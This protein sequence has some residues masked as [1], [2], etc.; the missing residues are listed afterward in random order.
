MTL[1]KNRLRRPVE[2]LAGVVGHPN[3][4][5]AFSGLLKSIFRA[6]GIELAAPDLARAAEAAS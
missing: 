4:S 2:G 1:P 3:A 5:T 6:I